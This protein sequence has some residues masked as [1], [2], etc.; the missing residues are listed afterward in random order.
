[1]SY[2]VELLS[3]GSGIGHVFINLINNEGNE[4]IR[5]FYPLHFPEPEALS[6][7]RS[8]IEAAVLDDSDHRFDSKRVPRPK[9]LALGSL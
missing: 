8:D 5:G 1:M 2:K 9:A 3:D 7:F 6:L 4:T